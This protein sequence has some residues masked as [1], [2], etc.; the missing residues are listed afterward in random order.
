MHALFGWIFFGMFLPCWGSL[1][2]G[3]PVLRRGKSQDGMG[4]EGLE[5]ERKM[6]EMKKGCE[7]DIITA[8]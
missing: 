2:G 3:F 4:F 5:D 8:E 1:V 6:R 7:L